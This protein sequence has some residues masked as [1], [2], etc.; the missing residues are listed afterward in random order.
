VAEEGRGKNEVAQPVN[1]TANAA[2]NAPANPAANALT[3]D[4]ANPAGNVVNNA[5]MLFYFSFLLF[6]GSSHRPSC[7]P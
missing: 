1:P 5:T 7:P 3:N 2:T 4:P 6:F